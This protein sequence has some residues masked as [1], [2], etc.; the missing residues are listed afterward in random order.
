MKKQIIVSLSVIAAVAAAAVGGTMALFSDTET[1]NGNIFTAGAIDLK[2]DHTYASY[3]GVDCKT[4][5]VDVYSSTATNV[6]AGTPNASS[7]VFPTAAV[8]VVSPH[9]GW[10]NEGALSPATWIWA[11]NPTTVADTTNG[12]E[13]T[14]ENKFQW[15][16]S[17]VSV[18][19]DLAIA[20]D[21]GYKIILNGTTIVDKLPQEF[22]YASAVSLTAP[23]E[24]AFMGAM[25]N[26]LNTLDI[27]V[28]N[29]PLAAD[30]VTGNPA[31][32][33]FNLNIHRDAQ[34]C[35][36]DSAFQQ[37]CR[38]WQSQDLTGEEQFF[39]F[40][41]VKPGDWGTNVIS[42]HV[43]SNDAYVCLAVADPVDNENIRIESEVPTDTTPGA[44]EGELSKYLNVVVWDDNGDGMHDAAETI[45]YSGPLSDL[46]TSR[47]TL[48]TT[49][50]GYLGMAWCAGTQTA[51]E[52]VGPI[53]CSGSGDHND[54]QTDSFVAN[55][56]ATAVQQRNNGQF[57]CPGTELEERGD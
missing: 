57:F 10:Q 32:L 33:L 38:L 3:N 18:V 40:D 1:S 17:A 47:L 22:T 41:D 36:A 42:L 52:G 16:G 37:T 44:F 7:L 49:A 15:N 56:V 2:V 27:I 28:R 30:P 45:L 8:D 5:S 31:G 11:T 34:E 53:T 13:Y 12:A 48:P 24:T 21:N 14:F 20:A 9:P 6:V 19:L 29:K 43:T 50:T 54:A 35:A 25:V 39:N 55:V 46:A 4:C 51:S 23:E 26:G